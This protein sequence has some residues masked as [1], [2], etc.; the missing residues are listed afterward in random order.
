MLFLFHDLLDPE[1]LKP[2]RSLQLLKKN[3][4]L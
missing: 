3:L 4:Y 1:H 2:G